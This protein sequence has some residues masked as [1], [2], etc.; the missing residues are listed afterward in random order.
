MKIHVL[1]T[2][3]LSAFFP[4]F[5]FS[6]P[7]ESKV[8]GKTAAVELLNVAKTK[9]TTVTEVEDEGEQIPPD[10][11]WGRIRRHAAEFKAKP[12]SELWSQKVVLRYC[13][14]N[15]LHS[16][17]MAKLTEKLEWKSGL[18]GQPAV[19]NDS[20]KYISYVASD[21]PH[22][23]ILR[24]HGKKIYSQNYYPRCQGD[25]VKQFYR[26]C[27]LTGNPRHFD[28]M[29]DC[30]D[31]LLYSQ[32]RE[33]GENSFVREWYLEKMS[34]E[35]RREYEEL[36]PKWVGGFD[37]LFDWKWKDGGGYTWRL[38]EPDHHVN[39][40]MAASL[41]LAYQATGNRRYLEASGNFVRHQIPRYGYH[42]GKWKGVRYYWTEYN[43][44]GAGNCVTDAYDNIMPYVA[45]NAAM[46]GY[47]ERNA[48][49][50]EYARGLLWHLVREYD[51]D[52][53]WLYGAAENPLN[54][55]CHL[56]ASHE[57]GCLFLALETVPYLI[58]SGISCDELLKCLD[59]AFDR[60][61]NADDWL[62]SR[63]KVNPYAIQRGVLGVRTHLGTV[64]KGTEMEIVD[65]LL[66]ASK[67][68]PPESLKIVL[69]DPLLQKEI[70][71]RGKVQVRVEKLMPS[72]K[73]PESWEAGAAKILDSPAQIQL[74][75][76]FEL[77]SGDL[78]RIRYRWNAADPAA[79]ETSAPTIK[80]AICKEQSAPD[81]K[82]HGMIVI[83][84]ECEKI[85]AQ[86]LFKVLAKINF[87]HP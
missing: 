28:R 5:C 17:K 2:L 61:A 45:R 32:Y 3:L 27:M 70:S 9:K 71:Q 6:E 26:S 78:I 41:A 68:T 24:P 72:K 85:D 75:E 53:R 12:V 22:H 84:L 38:H 25:F 83:P 69:T 15:T 60:Y 64:Q 42:T 39:S 48:A 40:D 66:V 7:A 76:L 55:T 86:S 36:S 50:L 46:V 34:P 77:H 8:S 20:G 19:Y 14:G 73:T 52:G 59:V 82:Q 4:C 58:A 35:E 33:G 56:S 47:Y 13:L 44:S 30:A 11:F 80:H 21:L 1:L 79:F 10:V 23:P 31:F 74:N 54:S 81:W 51:A 87:P 49:Y 16:Q 62:D 65:Y 37:Y 57:V 67:W 18:L 43:P 63:I 29:K